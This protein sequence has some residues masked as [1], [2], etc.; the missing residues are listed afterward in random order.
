MVAKNLVNSLKPTINEN[1]SVWRKAVLQ[2][3]DVGRMSA[4][5]DALSQFFVTLQGQYGNGGTAYTQRILNK[6][7]KNIN[8]SSP[9]F[10][11]SDARGYEVVGSYRYGRG[12]DIDPNG[13]FAQL[14]NQGPLQRLDTKSVDTFVNDL[15]RNTSKVSY[16][17]AQEL[18][19]GLFRAY[20][21]DGQLG[22]L[23]QHYPPQNTEGEDNTYS[24]VVGLR[25]WYMDSV[26][27][28]VAKAKIQLTN[29]AYT[30]ADLK[31]ESL[32][33]C[34]CKMA[35]ANI[36]LESAQEFSFV[37]VVEGFAELE[38][39]DPATAASMK[40]VAAAGGNW[41]LHQEA[42]R[43]TIEPN[44]GGLIQSISE[45]DETL[46]AANR[47]TQENVNEFVGG[48]VN[49]A[50]EAAENVDDTFGGDGE[51]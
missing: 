16:A 13:V 10:P 14:V 31:P 17:Q 19:Q 33:I 43:G 3:D 20:P 26:K 50:R 41:R 27:D 8:L 35:E 45:I 23:L 37:P 36:L 39:Q 34:H 22:T 30:L 47:A 15:M 42:L 29:A 51:V 32:Q 21:E 48:T 18:L 7:Q 25:S 5:K 12:V 40:S 28:G 46:E 49:T 4:R 6:K 1:I 11:V 9:V 24:L 44:L 2:S 38:E